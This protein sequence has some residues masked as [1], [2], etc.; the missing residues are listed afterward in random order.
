MLNLIAARLSFT[1]PN[2]TDIFRRAAAVYLWFLWDSPN[3]SRAATRPMNT[4]P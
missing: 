2:Q 4:S 3:Y 1:H